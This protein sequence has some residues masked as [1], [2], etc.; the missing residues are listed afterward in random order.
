MNRAHI[1]AVGVGVRHRPNLFTAT[2]RELAAKADSVGIAKVGQQRCPV[3]GAVARAQRHLVLQ[4]Y[5]SQVR[6][7]LHLGQAGGG[8]GREGHGHA[9]EVQQQ[10]VSGRVV[11][12]QGLAVKAGGIAACQLKRAAVQHDVACNGVNAQPLHPAQ[13]E[14]QPFGHQLGV[15]LAFEVQV[16]IQ[17]A[18]AHRAFHIH[19]RAPGVGRPQQVQRGKGSDQLH[20]RGRVHGHADSVAQSWRLLAFCVHH[21][22]RHRLARDF[23]SGQGGA[24]FGGQGLAPSRATQTA[25]AGQNQRREHTHHAPQHEGQLDGQLDWK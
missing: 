20:D 18:V 2:G 1:E 25:Q 19:R 12:P 5:A 17:R 8:I 15:A 22:Q 13:Q 10:R 24:D 7:K 9:L 11:R 4:L 23:G 14:P 16:A 3:I 21:Q 6:L